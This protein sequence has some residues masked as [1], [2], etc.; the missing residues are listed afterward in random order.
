[1]NYEKYLKEAGVEQELHSLAVSC[2]TEAKAKSEGLL[3][4]KWKVR[5]FKNKKIAELLDWEDERL[6]LKHPELSDWDI[7]PMLNITAHGDNVPWISTPQGGR[8]VP[9][10]WLDRDPNSLNYKS[11]VAS[12]YWLEGTHPR[13]K[14]SRAAWYRRNA[15]EFKAWSLGKEVDLTYGVSIWRK[16]GVT[17]Y[18]CGDAWQVIAYD[19]FLGI[20]PLA[21]RI[22]YE[23]SNLWIESSNAQAW[24]PVT[25][26]PLKAP[27]TWSVIPFR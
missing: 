4:S 7:A 1:M 17:V 18:N 3:W 13:S 26:Y 20:I 10:Q 16:N 25:G 6:C 27:V 5:L 22:G 9:G 24:Y 8:P 12:N 19:K 14:E 23:I 15:G 21:V 11:A 2:L